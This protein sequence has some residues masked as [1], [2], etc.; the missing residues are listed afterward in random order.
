MRHAVLSRALSVGLMK[1]VHISLQ[2]DV[3][4]CRSALTVMRCSVQPAA[5]CM[6]LESWV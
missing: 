1:L 2:W 6:F 5:A 3:E 4:P